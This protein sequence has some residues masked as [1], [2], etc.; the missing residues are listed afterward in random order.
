MHS[1]VN[2]STGGVALPVLEVLDI[3]GDYFGA[4]TPIHDM[5][6]TGTGVD[7]IASDTKV[8]LINKTNED[9]TVNLDNTTYSLGPYERKLVDR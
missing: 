2:V 7:G 8:Y 3:L 5:T 1:L 9:Q 4:G 6:I